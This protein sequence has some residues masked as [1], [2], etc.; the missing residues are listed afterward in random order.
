MEEI[1]ARMDFA[2]DDDPL[3]EIPP[4]YQSFMEGWEQIGEYTKFVEEKSNYRVDNNEFS[5]EYT[6]RLNSVYEHPDDREKIVVSELDMIVEFEQILQSKMCDPFQKYDI[7]LDGKATYGKVEDLRTEKGVTLGNYWDGVAESLLIQNQNVGHPFEDKIIEVK[8]TH[9]LI[10]YRKNN[11]NNSKLSKFCDLFIKRRELLFFEEMSSSF[12]SLSFSSRTNAMA[13]HDCSAVLKQMLIDADLKLT[14][15]SFSLGPSL[16][17][18]IVE[19]DYERP[20]EQKRHIKIVWLIEEKCI[21]FSKNDQGRKW[22]DSKLEYAA[23]IKSVDDINLL[24]L[25]ASLGGI[26]KLSKYI[27]TVYVSE[28]ESNVNS[29]IIDGESMPCYIKH[30]IFLYVLLWVPRFNSFFRRLELDFGQLYWIR[31]KMKHGG[32]YD[33]KTA[34]VVSLLVATTLKTQELLRRQ[35]EYYKLL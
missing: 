11:K 35:I 29:K 23:Q 33:T 15:Q 4:S 3:P 26:H 12:E 20:R 30:Y 10:I 5:A 8:E 6:N 19:E 7:I 2:L 24:A 14:G 17:A 32:L 25:M 34:H 16:I 21:T 18:E 13:H 22:I 9:Y 1:M 31:Q 27:G 28:F